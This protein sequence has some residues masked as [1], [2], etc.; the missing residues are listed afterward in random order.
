MKFCVLTSPNQWFISY[1]QKFSSENNIDLF[2]KH[3]DVTPDFDV[4]F[5]L[6]Y[7]RII[8]KEFLNK[9]KHN[10]VV[11]A[12]DLPQGKG[13]APVA[14]QILEGKNE[15]VF[16]LFEADEQA[17]NGPFYIKRTVKLTGYELNDEIRELQ[18][19]TCIDLCKEFIAN[20]EKLTATQQSGQ[21]SFYRKRN[22][23]DSELDINKSINEQFN[24]LRIVDNENYPAFFYKDNHKYIIKIYDGDQLFVYIGQ[25]LV[26]SFVFFDKLKNRGA[27]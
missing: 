14:W 20:Y 21:E 5:I 8:T 26:L 22:A 2:F 1:A 12:A 11:H 18:A 23:Q 3:E 27:F 16:T 10:I 4:V 25:L 17:D 6:S 9:H 7:H 19:Q 24:L 13:W 15:I